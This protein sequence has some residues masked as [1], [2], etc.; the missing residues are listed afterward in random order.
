MRC[1]KCRLVVSV[2]RDICP[3]CQFDL[4]PE[5]TKLG[6]AVS[7]PTATY[8]KLVEQLKI[9]IEQEKLLAAQNPRPKARPPKPGAKRKR[10]KGGSKKRQPEKAPPPG[11]LSALGSL[12]KRFLSKPKRESVPGEAAPPPPE[13]SPVQASTPEAVPTPGTP[14]PTVPVPVTVAPPEDSAANALS[15]DD[16]EFE[17]L[18]DDD[19]EQDVPSLSA[20]LLS[21]FSAILDNE[22]AGAKEITESL[23]EVKFDESNPPVPLTMSAPAVPEA[24]VPPA[25]QLSD[26]ETSFGKELE[27]LLKDDLSE[28]SAAPSYQDRAFEAEAP[29]EHG[30]LETPAAASFIAASTPAFAASSVAPEVVEF[31]DDDDRLLEEQLDEMLGDDLLEFSAV[32]TNVPK[33]VI[34]APIPDTLQVDDDL[35][36]SFEFDLEGY[37]EPETEEEADATRVPVEDHHPMLDEAPAEILASLETALSSLET[38]LEERS[39]SEDQAESFSAPIAHLEES[40]ERELGQVLAPLPPV[41]EILPPVELPAPDVRSTFGGSSFS[42]P[43]IPSVLQNDPASLSDFLLNYLSKSF[44]CDVQDLFESQPV[45]AS[46]VQEPAPG[47]EE[48]LLAS[49]SAELDSE[50][51]ALTAEGCVIHGVD[52]PEEAEPEDS[53]EEIFEE[54]LDDIVQQLE[55]SAP[56]E[57]IEIC[58]AEG[59]DFQD[60]LPLPV[61]ETFFPGEPSVDSQVWEAAESDLISALEQEEQTIEVSEIVTHTVDERTVVLFDTAIDALDDSRL[62]HAFEAKVITSVNRELENTKLEEVFEAYTDAAVEQ[63]ERASEPLPPGFVINEWVAP[64]GAA[65]WRRPLSYAIDLGFSFIVAGLYVWFIFLTDAARAQLFHEGTPAWFLLLPAV[66]NFGLALLLS[67]FALAF[68]IWGR[69]QTIG[70]RLFRCR[71]TSIDDDRVPLSAAFLRLS[72]NITDTCFGFPGV[73]LALG[74]QRRTFADRLS[75]TSISALQAE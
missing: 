43:L 6:F 44:G 68:L 39:V 51:S 64:P 7:D 71:T 50:L 26:D 13:N 15:V 49:L 31:H 21:E 33:P 9:S 18:F 16:L 63:F 67:H 8:E 61:D 54:N 5:K 75:D 20:E 3:D 14:P 25:F 73:L 2:R 38:E 65:L 4:R 60:N 23:R 52:A 74:S 72:A 24:P 12:A 59:A 66:W 40:L 34:A 48:D 36:I 47:I 32:R 70:Q 35:E 11:I 22:L 30:L 17:K 41:G 55:D 29:A 57:P 58:V 62:D 53:G 46:A 45:T 1:P 69:G 10:K 19:E 28:F 27:E 56:A 42:R 37:D